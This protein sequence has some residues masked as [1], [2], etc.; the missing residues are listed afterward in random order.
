MSNLA[1]SLPPRSFLALLNGLAKRNYHGETTFSNEVL[2]QEL[3][4]TTEAERPDI[5]TEILSFEDILKQAVEGHWDCA[6]LE[7][8]LQSRSLPAEYVRV[9]STFWGAERDRVHAKLVQRSTWNRQYKNL[10]WRVD[11]KTASKGAADLN[12]PVAFFELSS[13]AGHRSGPQ[14]ARHCVRFDMNRAEVAET[15]KALDKIQAAIDEHSY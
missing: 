3:W 7:E 6:H 2:I 11:I 1:C 13:D 12:E 9:F 14:A 5:P 8:V 4:S 15:L 10:A